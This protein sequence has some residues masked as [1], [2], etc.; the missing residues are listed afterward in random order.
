MSHAQQTDPQ[1]TLTVE[2]TVQV[3]P[4]ER[5]GA[6]AASAAA[7]A[8]GPGDRLVAPHGWLARNGVGPQSPPAIGA[9]IALGL[10]LAQTGERPGAVLA[11]VDRR[12]ARRPPCEAALALAREL[13]LGLVVV[14]IDRSPRTSPSG[15][16][17]DRDDPGAVAAA[18]ARALEGAREGRR[19]ALV[20]C[21]AV[22]RPRA[23][24]PA[25][26]G[27]RRWP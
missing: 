18:V 17:I 8:L 11:L 13:A 24:E 27:R 21:A 10:A 14:A 12:W 7:S 22:A 23:A 4:Q 2:G 25:R 20:E 3:R 1:A 9:G 15:Q 19:P 5:Q 6:V 26:K 16:V